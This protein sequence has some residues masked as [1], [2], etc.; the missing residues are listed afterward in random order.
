MVRATHDFTLPIPPEQA[1]AVLSNPGL[2]AQWQGS[3]LSSRLLADAPG[4]G[5]Q[6]DIQFRMLGKSL[7]FR[8]EITDFEEGKVSGY[9]TV[10]GPFSYTGGYSYT[11]SDEGC[12]LGWFFDVD[13]G[14]FFGLLPISL[15]RKALISQVEKDVVH[16]RGLLAEGHFGVLER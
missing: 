1:F 10:S 14:R 12:R 6:Y 3:C 13:P 15:M 8:G 9:K 5:A 4:P 7:D 16:L 11:P 2:D